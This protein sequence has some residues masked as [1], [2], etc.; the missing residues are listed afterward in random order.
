MNIVH[1]L[2]PQRA[3]CMLLAQTIAAFDPALVGTVKSVL[4][5]GAQ[6]TLAESILL[7]REALAS[8]RMRGEVPWNQ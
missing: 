2:V 3:R 6:S 1:L 8:R 7:E 4:D 5:R